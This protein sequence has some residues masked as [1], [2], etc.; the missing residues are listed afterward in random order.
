MLVSRQFAIGDLGER[1]DDLLA[2]VHLTN[3]A[4]V[5]NEDF[6]KHHR[7]LADFVEDG[8]NEVLVVVACVARVQQLQEYSLQE[9]LYDVFK[10]LAE[11][12]EQAEKDGDHKGEDLPFIRHT[13]AE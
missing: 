11:V 12:C 1:L 5:V 10:V 3:I 2:D 7:V 6:Q 9:Y 13:I 8:Q 4:I